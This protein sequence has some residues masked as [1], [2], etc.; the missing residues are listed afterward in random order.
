MQVH[1]NPNGSESHL[2]KLLIPI[3]VA[4]AVLGKQGVSHI[5]CLPIFFCEKV[6]VTIFGTTHV[7]LLQF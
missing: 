3:T 6:L 4:G 2:F 5:C 7:N 1:F